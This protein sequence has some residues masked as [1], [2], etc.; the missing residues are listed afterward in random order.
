MDTKDYAVSLDQKD[1][2][3]HFRDEFI[4]PSNADLKRKKRKVDCWYTSMLES[5]LLTILQGMK[6]FLKGRVSIFV[7]TR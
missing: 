2:L 1:P 4:I 5:F 6:G 7:A 3:H